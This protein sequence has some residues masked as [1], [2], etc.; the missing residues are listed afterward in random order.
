MIILNN[1]YTKVAKHAARLSIVAIAAFSTMACASIS[2]VDTKAAQTSAVQSSAAVIR[3]E[4]IMPTFNTRPSSLSFEQ[5]VVNAQAAIDKR[6]FKTFNVID[7]AAGAASIDEALN[8]TTLIIFGNPKGGTPLMQSAQ[9]MGLAL[10]LKLL[11]ME[12][13][14]GT[15]M[16]A[17]PDMALIFAA[18]GVDDRQENLTKI[19]GALNA[20]A[21]EAS[22]E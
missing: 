1:S 9:T 10:P 21:S 11:V 2:S 6:G 13:E 20:I 15:V 16:L 22:G 8:P 5:T 12:N 4:S 3:E 19:E 14:D 17:W 18:H 7:H